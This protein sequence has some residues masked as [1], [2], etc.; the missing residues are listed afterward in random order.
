MVDL[1]STLKVEVYPVEVF[2]C[3]HSNM[4]SVTTAQFSRTDTIREFVSLFVRRSSSSSSLT[5]PCARVC[6]LHPEGGVSGLLRAPG[7]GVSTVDEEF[8]QQL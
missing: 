3:L 1:P 7:L 4:E 8:G 2:L 5:F 6:R